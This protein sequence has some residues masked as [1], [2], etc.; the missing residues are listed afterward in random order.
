MLIS[1]WIQYH[2]QPIHGVEGRIAL[3][4][5]CYPHIT[6]CYPDLPSGIEKMKGICPDNIRGQKHNH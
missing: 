4:S 5:T 2:L 3:L 6:I 1:P